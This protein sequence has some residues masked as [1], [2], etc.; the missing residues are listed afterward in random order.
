MK[1]HQ[2][3]LMH[4]HVND[5]NLI[6]KQEKVTILFWNYRVSLNNLGL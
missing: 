5:M 1:M 6:F 4:L 2:H 3:L